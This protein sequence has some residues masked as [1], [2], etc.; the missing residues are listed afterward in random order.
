MSVGILDVD[1]GYEVSG[2]SFQDGLSDFVDVA[3]VHGEVFLIDVVVHGMSRREGQVVYASLLVRLFL[4]DRISR[5]CSVKWIGSGGGWMGVRSRDSS[6]FEFAFQ[7][8]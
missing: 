6:E 2:F 8:S 1:T 7:I 3:V 4:G 5:C